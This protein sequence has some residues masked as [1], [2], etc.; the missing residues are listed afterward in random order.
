MK[1]NK[2]EYIKVACLVVIAVSL[3]VIAWK[4]VSQVNVL[5][6]IQESLNRIG[7]RL[8]QLQ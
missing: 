3:S 4:T 2:L 1:N 6:D 5:Q 8:S 7:I